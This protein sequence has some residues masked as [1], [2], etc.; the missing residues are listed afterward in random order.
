MPD[1]KAN[2]LIEE[3][4]VTKTLTIEVFKCSVLGNILDKKS[5]AI[6]VFDL[7]PIV[8]AIANGIV[9]TKVST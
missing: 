9:L 7:A 3:S 4:S 8:N 1:C 6:C 2:C 5:A